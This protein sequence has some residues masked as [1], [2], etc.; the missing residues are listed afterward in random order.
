MRFRDALFVGI[1]GLLMAAP[2]A[3]GQTFETFSP[4][5]GVTSEQFE[6]LKSDLTKPKA[7]GLPRQS[8]PMARNLSMVS[9]VNARIVGGEP[10]TIRDNPWQAALIYGDIYAPEPVRQQFCGGSV[11]AS[12]W[13]VTAAHCVGGTGGTDQVDIV[14]G[15]GTYKHGGERIKV[16]AVFV[17]PNYNSGTQQ[18]DIALIKLARPTTLGKAVPLAQASLRLPVNTKVTVAGWGAVAE[19]GFG[20]EILLRVQVPIVSTEEC[21][22]PEVYGNRILP[23]MLCAG[24]RTGGLDSC[25]GDSGGP[26]TGKVNDIPTLVGVVSWGDGCARELKY[27]IYSEVSLFRAWIDSVVASN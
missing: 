17:N 9:R 14:T 25:Q 18:N 21:K 24:Y 1:A 10:T 3:R 22:R 11:I 26:L 27:G 16:A 2:V 23:G 8:E 5:A 12:Q 4:G 15:T 19:G 6:K 13:V 20:S 7:L